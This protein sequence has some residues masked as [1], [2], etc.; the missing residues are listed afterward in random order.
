MWARPPG[1]RQDCWLVGGSFHGTE[2]SSTR[3]VGCPHRRTA[4]DGSAGAVGAAPDRTT[5]ANTTVTTTT[6]SAWWVH[7]IS[8]EV[9]SIPAGFTHYTILT[10]GA[11]F[12][13]LGGSTFASSG[14][15]WTTRHLHSLHLFEGR[16]EGVQT[17]APLEVAVILTFLRG[18]WCRHTDNTTAGNGITGGL[19]QWGGTLQ[20][21]LDPAPKRP[22]IVTSHLSYWTDN[23]AYYY[24]YGAQAAD[25]DTMAHGPMD[26]VLRK[27]IASWQQLALPVRSIQIDDWWHVSFVPPG[28]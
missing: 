2:Y 3:E 9:Q 11:P 6:T 27:L 24:L 17:H 16:D 1:D 26:K 28:L 13:F 12:F 20:K 19:Q 21:A 22:D 5:A 7:G 15:C 8:G 14:Q 25:C 10:V 23:G 18:R 4:I